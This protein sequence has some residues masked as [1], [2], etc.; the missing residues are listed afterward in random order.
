[1]NV[2]LIGLVLVAL[3]AA[4]GAIFG[5]NSWLAGQRAALEAANRNQ[6]QV[7]KDHTRIIVA[8]RGLPAGTQAESKRPAAMASRAGRCFSR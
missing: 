2:R 8:K 7:K 1:M 6:V 4:G 5:A 3:L